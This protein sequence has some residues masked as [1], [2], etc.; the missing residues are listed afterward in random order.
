MGWGGLVSGRLGRAAPGVGAPLAPDS[1]ELHVLVTVPLVAAHDLPRL[2][3]VLPGAP[4]SG[5]YNKP[6]ERWS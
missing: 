6:M 3:A 4:R 1:A 2:A 5:T